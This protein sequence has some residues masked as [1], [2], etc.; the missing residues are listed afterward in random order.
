MNTLSRHQAG[1]S[2][3]EFMI[4]GTLGLIL[5]AG[6]MQLFLATRQTQSLQ[7]QSQLL[8]ENGMNALSFIRREIQRSGWSETGLSA[9]DNPINFSLANYATGNGVS[10]PGNLSD[11]LALTFDLAA[12][13]VDCAGNTPAN[14]VTEVFYVD[15]NGSLK[16]RSGNQEVE[17]VNGVESLQFQFG[18][19]TRPNAT[20]AFRTPLLYRNAGTVTAAERNNL[21]SVRMALLLRSPDKPS[22][23]GTVT[24][25]Y[26]LLD[27]AALNKASDGY[28]R[29]EFQLTAQLPN[30]RRD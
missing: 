24:T 20:P 1:F 27:A 11:R 21:I 13:E 25:N 16:C 8:R 28:L 17:L 19:D 22:G 14:P 10:G 23:G 29:R 7:A 3:I 18:V 26:S 5:T 2:L 15:A 30:T 9:R 6:A 12:D 4:A